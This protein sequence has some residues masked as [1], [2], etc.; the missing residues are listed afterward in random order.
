M[1]QGLDL[2]QLLLIDRSAIE[3]WR[4][5]PRKRFLNR[6]YGG[7]GIVRKGKDIPMATGTEL[8][9][10]VGHILWMWKE[11]KYNERD[12]LNTALG[13][14]KGD[15][16]KLVQEKGLRGKGT[17]TDYRK[18]YTYLEQVNLVEAM[19]R[20]WHLR[21][22][23]RITRRF[24]V[25]EVERE[26]LVPLDIQVGGK[27][28]YYQSRTD[29]LL[30]D[31]ENGDCLVYSLKTAKEFSDRTQKS[32]KHDEQGLSEIWASERL[33]TKARKSLEAHLTDLE[34]GIPF[35]PGREARATQKYVDFIRKG[36]MP[37]KIMGVSFCFLVKGRREE[38]SEGVYA[39]RSPLIRPYRKFNPGGVEY[40]HSY[41][42][43]NPNNK[44]GWGAI[45][46]GWEQFNVWEQE[47]FTLEDWIRKLDRMEIQPECGDVLSQLVVS[48]PE[49]WRKGDEI[50]DWI[51]GV[52]QS[53]RRIWQRLEGPDYADPDKIDLLVLAQDFPMSRQ[54]CHWPT[55]CAYLPWCYNAMVREDPFGNSEAP[56][57]WR[58]PHHEAERLQK[59]GSENDG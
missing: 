27:Y 4:R 10:A 35:M 23:P 17:E 33:M 29:A 37:E 20:V 11:G 9:K 57:E 3:T 22:F 45:G 54:S 51:E 18:E 41:Y 2:N 49:Y 46:K 31:K 32:Y 12:T 21:E 8:H 13:L 52:K 48:P 5:C 19:V 14:A 59:E 28:L 26:K 42:Y 38:V 47:E 6:H 56:Y 1:Y 7:R 43:P 39:T 40:A 58:V 24:D 53:E 50:A 44:S 30:R 25:L 16:G 36:N 55:E 15:Y 34:V